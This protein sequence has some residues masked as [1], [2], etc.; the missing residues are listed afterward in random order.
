MI[1][2]VLSTL[3]S[4]VAGKV[5]ADAKDVLAILNILFEEL[6]IEMKSGKTLPII[7]FGHFEIKQLKE[8]GHNDYQT[9]T[10][11]ISPGRKHIRFLLDEGLKGCLLRHLS[12]RKTFPPQ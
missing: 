4:V 11:M 2:T 3:A 5:G 8:H 6:L 7:G 12:R 9:H 10:W 1:K